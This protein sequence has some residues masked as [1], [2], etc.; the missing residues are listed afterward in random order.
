M[1]RL[2]EPYVVRKQRKD[3]IKVKLNFERKALRLLNSMIFNPQSLNLRE[4]GINSEWKAKDASGRNQI[5]H[6]QKWLQTKVFEKIDD[7]SFK[8]PEKYSGALPQLYIDRLIEIVK[9]YEP[10]GFMVAYADEYVLLLNTL[11]GKVGEDK[12][13][14]ELLDY[15]EI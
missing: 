8:I 10:I 12:A 1:L 13:L 4:A 14:N 15:K 7:S 9:Y 6:I 3:K 11:E 2:V 5:I